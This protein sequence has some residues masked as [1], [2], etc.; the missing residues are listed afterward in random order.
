MS[1]LDYERMLGLADREV[2]L[3]QALADHRDTTE[4]EGTA[5]KHTYTAWSAV[6]HAVRETRKMTRAEATAAITTHA[7]DAM[8]WIQMVHEEVRALN[9][10]LEAHDS[11]AVVEAASAGLDAGRMATMVLGYGKG[12]VTAYFIDTGEMP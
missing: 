4:V 5:A 3:W 2:E 6:G 12:F 10:L 11:E 7:R 9:D 1:A 8:Q